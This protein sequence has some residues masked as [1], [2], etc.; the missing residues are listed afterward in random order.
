[1]VRSLN[2]QAFIRGTAAPGCGLANTPIASYAYTLGPT[3]NRLSV[4]ELSGR[5]VIYGYDDLYRLTSEDILCGTAPGCAPGTV[6]YSYDK[7]GNRLQRN[8]TLPAVPATG[9]LNYDANAQTSTDPYDANGNLLLSGAGTN[10]Y[11]FENRLVSAGGVKLVYDGDGN[12]VQETVATTTTSYLVADQNLTGYAQVL[13][14]LQNGSVSRTYSYGLELI[15]ERQSI[16]GTLTTSFY[17]F[18]GHGSIRFLTD[19]TG[20][21]TDTYDYDAYRNLISRELAATTSASRF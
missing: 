9:L 2:T 21:I 8:S 5:T 19:S 3:G 15:N 1:M 13:D 10:V 16:A 18:D 7:V 20:A 11:D 17:G 14:E 6:S 4:A 12:R